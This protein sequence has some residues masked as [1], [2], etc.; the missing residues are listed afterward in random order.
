M[1]KQTIIAFDSIC[2]LFTD[3]VFSV[4]EVFLKCRNKSIPVVRCDAVVCNAKFLEFFTE[5]ISGLNVAIS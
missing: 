1:A 4:R 2:I 5:F 3:V